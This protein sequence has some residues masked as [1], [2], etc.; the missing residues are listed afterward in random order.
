MWGGGG[1]WMLPWTPGDG[2]VENFKLCQAKQGRP[3]ELQRPAESRGTPQGRQ[4]KSTENTE[5]TLFLPSC[6]SDEPNW[7]FTS[8]FEDGFYQQMVSHGTT[9]EGLE[10]TGKVAALRVPNASSVGHQGL[11]A[12]HS[13]AASQSHAELLLIDHAWL[14]LKPEPLDSVTLHLKKDFTFTETSPLAT[15]FKCSWMQFLFRYRVHLW[16]VPFRSTSIP[17]A[18][19][20]WTNTSVRDSDGSWLLP[21][22]YG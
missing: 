22:P 13:P 1:E 20:W 9:E 10:A 7:G 6:L 19:N 8:R 4:A 3:R 15:D 14:L 17:V 21:R 18:A 16:Q 12:L 5:M 2:S 11:P